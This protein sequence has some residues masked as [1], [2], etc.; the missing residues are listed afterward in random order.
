MGGRPGQQSGVHGQQGGSV[1]IGPPESP[2]KAG[3]SSLGP[4]HMPPSPC[5]AS[6]HTHNPPHLWPLLSGTFSPQAPRGA[7]PWPGL[8]SHSSRQPRPT[9]CPS[10]A[11]SIPTATCASV[12]LLI[13][14]LSHYNG[15]QR[16]PRGGRG[17][18]PGHSV[19]VAGGAA[20]GSRDRGAERVCTGQSG[21][22]GSG[23]LPALRLG[24]WGLTQGCPS[25]ARVHGRWGWLSAS[26]QPQGGGPPP[27][28][29]LPMV[30]APG[31]G[32][33]CSGGPRGGR[34]G[35]LSTVASCT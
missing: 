14:G 31:R 10:S 4:P 20:P 26:L 3:G 23:P 35:A 32:G 24:V 33:A 25:A 2:R 15:G 29:R 11:P 17:T 12:S 8:C 16:P 28:P 19:L 27:G 30:G 21:S 22:G 5:A 7:S 34:R 6:G 9:P 1:L 18:G 13:T